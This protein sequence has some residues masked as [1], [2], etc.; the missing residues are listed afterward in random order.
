LLLP[1]DRHVTGTAASG[2]LLVVYGI[3][4]VLATALLAATFTQSG[5]HHADRLALVLTFELIGNLLLAAFLIPSHPALTASALISVLIASSVLFGW[6][7]RRVVM[8]AAVAVAGFAAVAL[9]TP[10]FADGV[11][12]GIALATLLVGAGVAI[13]SARLLAALHTRVAQR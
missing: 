9:G 7:V 13:V 12:A 6:S 5:M 4:A 8:L 10:A 1:V 2:T 3:N 11:V